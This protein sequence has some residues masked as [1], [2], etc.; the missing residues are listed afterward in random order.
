MKPTILALALLLAVPF[1]GLA[2]P[3]GD[4]APLTA[5]ATPS[6]GPAPLALC[7]ALPATGVPQAHS[8]Q[9]SELFASTAVET[10][11]PSCGF[12]GCLGRTPGYPC[13]AGPGKAGNC[14][15]STNICT[16]GLHSCYCNWRQVE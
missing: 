11:S 4:P 7:A 6:A 16:D 9:G 5:P 1:L 10:C 8:G 3:S 2:T 12:G 13:L 15:L 14:T